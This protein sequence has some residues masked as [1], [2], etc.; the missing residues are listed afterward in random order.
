MLLSHGSCMQGLWLRQ[1]DRLVVRRGLVSRATHTPGGT[2]FAVC[3]PNSAATSAPPLSSPSSHPSSS[4]CSPSS[5]PTPCTAAAADLSSSGRCFN[6]VVFVGA[7]LY[8]GSD[9]ECSLCMKNELVVCFDVLLAIVVFECF[10]FISSLSSFCC[11]CNNIH[12]SKANNFRQPY[13]TEDKANA[14]KNTSFY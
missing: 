8:N 6:G 13:A 7:S 12:Y 11:L 9:N 4:S 2:R 1:P 10:V 14:V 3:M 5:T